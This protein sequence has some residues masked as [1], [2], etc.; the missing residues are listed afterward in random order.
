MSLPTV[1]R[2]VPLMLLQC[3][4]LL[5]P[6]L[7]Q[8]PQLL[9]R[10]NQRCLKPPSPNLLPL[11]GLKPSRLASSSPAPGLTCHLSNP[12]FHDLPRCTGQDRPPRHQILMRP[13][14]HLHRAGLALCLSILISSLPWMATRTM[15]SS[16]GRVHRS[17]NLG[18][19]EQCSRVSL[20]IFHAILLAKRHR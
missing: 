15:V 10:P 6:Q 19:A 2:R 7:L 16:D 5:M 17:S 20:N 14:S 9:L 8:L 4:V 11:V 1:L 13:R 18:S 3:R 12:L